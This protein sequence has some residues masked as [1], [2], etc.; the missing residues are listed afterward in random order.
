MTKG[1]LWGFVDGTVRAITR[2]GIHQRVLYNGPKRYYAL[3]FQSVAATNDLIANLYRPVEDKKHGSCMLM[4][5]G[6]LN[7]FQ[8]YSFVQNQR[9]LCIYG[10]SAYPLRIHLQAGFKGARLF[11]QQVD[12]NARMSEVRVSFEWIFLD[13]ITYF[14]FLD[15]KKDLKIGLRPVG[16]IYILCALLHNSRACLYG[17]TT[18]TYFDC[19]PPKVEEYFA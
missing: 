13:I 7:Q 1:S 14:K 9:P 11:Q 19:D 8:Q 4:D 17:K 16:K 12:W 10:D 18:S 6:L 15:F 3:K 2:S 5:S